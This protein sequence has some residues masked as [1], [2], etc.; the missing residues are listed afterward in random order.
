MPQS[1]TSTWLKFALQQMAAE[2]YLDNIDLHN[3]EE[4]TRFLLL[5]NNREGFPETGFTRFTGTLAQGQAKDFVQRYQIVDHHANDATGFSATLM[6]DTTTNTYTLSFRSTEFPNQV[7]GGDWE[8]DG[9]PGADGEIF[10]HGFAFAQ[11]VSMERYYRQLVVDPSKLPPGAMLNVT[12]YSLGG[13]LATIFTE[14]HYQDANI[15]FGQTTTFNGAGRGRIV[16]QGQ[17]GQPEVQ[18]IRRMLLDLE[19]RLLVFDPTGSRF[20]SGAAGNIYAEQAYDSARATTQAQFVTFGT[21]SIGSTGVGEARSGG[22]FDKI[23]QLIGKGLTGTDAFF[24]ANS[25]IHAPSTAIMIEGQPQIEGRNEQGQLQFGNTHSLTLLVDSLAVQALFER[26]D[27]DLIQADI[28]GMLQAASNA[29]SDTFST[30]ADQHTAEGNTLERALDALRT[31]FVPNALDKTT[32]FNDDTGGFGDLATRTEFYTHL[33]EVQAAV[34]NQTFSIEPLV[35]RDSQG[36]V[37]PRL[38]VA[39]LALAAQD[40]GDSGLAY[41]YALKALNP[42][43]VIGVDYNALGHA[44]NGVLTLFDPNTGFGEMTEQ[45]LTD[46]AAFLLAQLDLTLANFPAPLIPSLTHYSDVAT[47]TDERTQLGSG[48]SRDLL[49]I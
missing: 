21:L 23:T 11:L 15:Q 39:E 5:G 36:H 6:K 43:A 32:D 17:E 12:G 47:G 10:D 31:L 29:R 30:T 41:R 44:S 8:R 19:A 37:V 13:H 22:A 28:E 49:C 2:S 42:F 7:Q 26:L 35:Q 4:V 34:V 18:S 38:T 14:L 16:E 46:R 45:Y 20:Q 24:I 9:R 40:P 1:D 27:P 25:G 48:M 3:P 33:A